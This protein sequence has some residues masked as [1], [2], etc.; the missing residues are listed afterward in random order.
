MKWP[1]NHVDRDRFS[2]RLQQKTDGTKTAI[3]PL[4]DFTARVNPPPPPPSDATCYRAYNY[5]ISL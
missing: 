2:G 3:M 1:I 4:V 5:N